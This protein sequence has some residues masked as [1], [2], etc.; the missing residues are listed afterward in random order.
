MTNLEKWKAERI[1]EIEEMD[2]DRVVRYIENIYPY[3]DKC[4]QCI[5]TYDTWKCREF[6]CAEG[7]KA[8]LDMEVEE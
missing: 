1:K 4:E 5:H 6:K 2:I 7:I 3:K 8:Y